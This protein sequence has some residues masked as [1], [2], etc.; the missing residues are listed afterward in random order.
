MNADISRQRRGR[1]GRTKITRRRHALAEI[2]VSNSIRTRI[3]V[4]LLTAVVAR[5]ARMRGRARV[6]DC[7]MRGEIIGAKIVWLIEAQFSTYFL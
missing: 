4:A 7:G 2:Y 1:E 5:V 6:R 3:A